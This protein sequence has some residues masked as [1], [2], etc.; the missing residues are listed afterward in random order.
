[1]IFINQD[2]HVGGGYSYASAGSPLDFIVLYL[3]VLVMPS[4]LLALFTS[5]LGFL[6]GE[7]YGKIKNREKFSENKLLYIIA[8]FAIFLVTAIFFGVLLRKFFG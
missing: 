7:V 2:Y 4:V 8:I 6:F 1:M 3:A 5:G